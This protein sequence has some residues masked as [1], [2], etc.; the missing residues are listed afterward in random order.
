MGLLRN[1]LIVAFLHLLAILAIVMYEMYGITM[2][3]LQYKPAAEDQ[4]LMMRAAQFSQFGAASV[5]KSTKI[6]RPAC[7]S[8]TQVLIKVHTGALNPVDF[9]QRR[10]PAPAMMRPLPS[11]SGFDFSGT[12]EAVGKNVSIFKANDHVY[13]LLPLLGQRW[14]AF[15]EYVV[16]ESSIIAPAPKSVSLRD[17]AGLPLVGLTVVHALQPVLAHWASSGEST[18]GKIILVHAGAGGVGSFAIQFCAHVLKMQVITTASASNSDFVKG[19]GAHQ[20]I[21]YRAV[22]F[23]DVVRD[24]DVILDTVT[25]EYE[26]RTFNNPQVLKKGGSGHY[27][28]I[29]STDWQPSSRE[30]NPLF[31]MVPFLKKWA[32]SLLARFGVGVHYHC[33]PV[34]PDG[35][36]LKDIAAW[37]DAGLLRPI[38]D[39]AFPLEETDKAHEYLEQGHAKGKVLIEIGSITA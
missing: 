23:E 11:V 30:G 13:G 24:V 4:E 27:C 25:Q 39:R 1:L 12:V 22:K 21:D 14:G 33:N 17:T 36:S 37:V 3:N 9:K 6:P 5:V 2:S 26:E 35:E 31:V 7:C 18:D 38:I 15:Q 34:H 32:Y 28:H 20:V 29:L 19:L 10:M 16:A 8:P